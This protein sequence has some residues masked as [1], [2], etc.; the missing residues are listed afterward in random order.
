M[1]SRNTEIGLVLPPG[2]RQRRA[3]NEDFGAIGVL[4]LLL[5]GSILVPLLLAA[6]AGWLSYRASYERTTTALVKA[7]AAAQ[8]NTTKI[9]D[10]HV[11][12][13]ARISDLLSGLS[14]DQVRAQE[15]ALHQR[16]ADQ[17]DGLPQVAAAWVI[18]RDGHALV[19]ARVFPV[20][21]DLDQS[22]R[23]D[24]RILQDTKTPPT[25]IWALRARSL[26]AGDFHPYFTVS[27]RRQASDGSFQGVIVIAVSGE[28]FASFYGAL[29]S[30][31]P[32]YQASVIREDGSSLARYPDT[33]PPPEQHDEP[34]ANAIAE[35]AI[36]GVAAGGDTFSGNGSV[37]AY[38]RLADYPVYVAIA[39][40]KASIR[41]EW[42]ES[43]VGYA[44]IGISAALGLLMLS[45]LALRRAQREKHAIE[46]ARMI[47]DE[48][49][50]AQ[51]ARTVELSAANQRLGQTVAAL[52]S[53][54]LAAEAASKAKSDFLANMSHELRTPL[55]A[56]IGFSDMMKSEALGPL[57]NPTYRGYA[58]DINFSGIHL[59]EIIDDIL[60]VVR[61]EAGK[62]ELK[63]EAVHVAQ[64]VEDVLR[65]MA[66]H[67]IEAELKLSWLS[68]GAIQPSLYCDR[69]RLRQMLLNILSN[70]I[71]FSHR[72]GLVEISAEASDGITIVV[73]DRG[74]GI[75]P[76]DIERILTPFGQ[77]ASVYSR[78]HQGIGLGLP[79]TKALVECH[80][81]RLTLYSAVGIGTEVRLSF[82]PER[83]VWVQP[84][85]RAE[86]IAASD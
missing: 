6:S 86:S 68:V 32:Q 77:V 40:T 58:A 79:L 17:I 78:N 57:G 51:K 70:A 35:G 11:L 66:P 81:G 59:T 8:E 3:A 30:G 53:A 74:I 73:K 41:H 84:E 14:D 1:T 2:T 64:M 4:R 18:D 19:S 47:E 83:V 28:Y 56:I 29:L 46:R 16:I 33:E 12:V 75:D 65:L 63:E 24:V 21:R 15:E 48:L 71:K 31:L 26:D 36:G 44:V 82:P 22:S 62:V 67:A 43:I 38:K 52:E 10:T 45:S 69:L 76:A 39:R 50:Q 49:H 27:R 23:D 20:N 54:K 61:H 60:D 85:L 34:L 72:G 25:L 9:L 37:I 5:V 80:G 13:A 55:N 42:L 7:A